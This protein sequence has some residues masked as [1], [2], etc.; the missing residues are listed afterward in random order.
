MKKLL[1]ALATCLMIS[2]PLVAQFSAQ[3]AADPALVAEIA[4]IK[5]IDNHAHPARVVGPGEKEDVEVDALTLEGLEPSPLPLRLRPDNPEYIA[6]WRALYGYAYNDMSEAH[7]RELLEAK[8]RVMRERSDAYPAWVLDQLG[9]ETMLANRAA[10]GRGLVAP[11]F[12]WVSFV[13]ALMLPLSNEGARRENPDYAHFYVDEERLLK[14]YLAESNVTARPQTLD[15]YVTKVVTATLERQKREGALAVK[16]EAAY[17]R[18]LDFA[19]APKSQ[20][21]RVYARYINGGE[22]AADEYKKLQDFLFRT[23]AHEAGRLGLAVD[24]RLGTAE[25]LEAEDNSVDAVV[26]TLVLCT[27]PDVAATLQEVL[28]VLKPGGRFLFMEHVAAPR[29][30]RL[31]RVQQWIRP[32][33]KVIG[34]GCH[35]DRETWTIIETAGFDSVKIEHFQAPFPIFGPHIMGEAIKK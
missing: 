26:S 14:R 24:L 11:R 33:W 15:E 19:D 7:V 28:R 4:K 22:P 9:I 32:L 2:L 30:T 31:R 10:M 3:T 5:A 21:E 8:R 18:S 35:P 23:I 1:L 25:R 27:V 13:D 34:D 29:G 16:F 20:A 17:L 12:R 6:A